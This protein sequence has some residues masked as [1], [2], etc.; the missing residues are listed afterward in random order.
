MENRKGDSGAGSQTTRTDQYYSAGFANSRIPAFANG[1]NGKRSPGADASAGA[2]LR[3]AGIRSEHTVSVP[4]QL[5][6]PMIGDQDVNLAWR[7][8]QIFR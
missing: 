7:K 6:R 3:R 8:Y 5:R 2:T 1:K 4:V